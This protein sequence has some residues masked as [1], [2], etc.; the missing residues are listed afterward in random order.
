MF[1]V[2]MF[3]KRCLAS[4][5]AHAMWGVIKQ[6]FAFKS[7]LSGMGGSAERTSR[8]APAIFSLLRANARSFSL[9]NIPRLV[10]MMKAVGFINERVF[11]LIMFLVSSVSAQ[12]K[13]I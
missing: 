3:I 11:V 2:A 9:I 7:G 10:F 12:F 5:V 1:V 6:F 4:F 8:P 13:L